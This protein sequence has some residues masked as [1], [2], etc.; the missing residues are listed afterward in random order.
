[1]HWLVQGFKVS[2]GFRGIPS[3][4]LSFIPNGGEGVVSRANHA[5]RTF[6]NGA[7][8][9]IP[10]PRG[11]ARGEDYPNDSRIEPLQPQDAQA[12]DNQMGDLEVQG[13]RLL[14]ISNSPFISHS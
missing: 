11:A 12:V 7:A 9:R 5:A 13:E 8:R 4:T 6:E 14:A 10:S 3:S 2:N 1:M